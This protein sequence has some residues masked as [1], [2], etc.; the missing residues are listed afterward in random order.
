MKSSNYLVIITGGTKGLGRELAIH[1]SKRHY[2]VLSLYH[3]DVRAAQELEQYF[4]DNNL[5]GACQKIDIASKE[6]VQE[7]DIDNIRKYSKLI[8]INNAVFPFEPKPFHHFSEDEYLN[9]LKTNLMG[10]LHCTNHLLKELINQ[11]GEIISILSEVI[12]GVP[13]GFAPYTISKY[14][15]L[16]LM[17][18]LVSEYCNR[19]LKI[20]NILPSFM[21]T[22][23]TKNWPSLFKE[24]ESKG[25]VKPK[26]IASMICELICSGNALGLGE[27][28]ITTIDG[29]VRRK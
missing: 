11:N 27:E 8:L 15:L 29:C 1:F 23:L 13:K 4:K 16:G 3:A 7:I 26:E 21:N 5:Q 18:S 25:S 12:V 22:T 10:A 6:N 24:S 14:A 19:G 17:K 9:H 28:Y 2:D 20:Y